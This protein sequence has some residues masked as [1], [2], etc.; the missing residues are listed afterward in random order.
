MSTPFS[1]RERDDAGDV[2]IRADRALA[3]AD[4]IRLVRLEAVDR[5][6]VL[7]RVD[8]HG[9]EAQFGGR[10]KDADGD[11]AAVGDEQFA[12]AGRWR[13]GFGRRHV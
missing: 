12:L 1:L 10:A 3:L 9:A 8:G 2:E 4:Q 11:F 5:E 6:P 13:K 7:L